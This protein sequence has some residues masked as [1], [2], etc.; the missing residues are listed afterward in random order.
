MAVLCNNSKY[1]VSKD[2]KTNMA[3]T[4]DDFAQDMDCLSMMLAQD[5]LS[6]YSLVREF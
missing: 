6:E 1:S 5:N 4:M 2:T 3:H